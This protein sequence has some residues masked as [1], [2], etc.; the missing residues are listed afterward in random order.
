MRPCIIMHQ[1]HILADISC[2][3]YQIVC[4]DFSNV[5]MRRGYRL[6]RSRRISPHAF[7][8]G[9]PHR[10]WGGHLPPE[11]RKSLP[12]VDTVDSTVDGQ[13]EVVSKAARTVLEEAKKS[14]NLK[15]TTWAK[16]KAAC[17]EILAAADK[18]ADRGE[19]SE[20]I[21]KMAA[22]N[23]RMREELALLRQ[24]TKALR[25]A[26]SE[27]K[28]PDANPL[29]STANI[30]A[31][32]DRSMRSFGESL[33]RNLFL[34]LGGMVNDRIKELE[35]RAIFAPQEVLRPP[36]AADRRNKEAEK[37]KDAEKAEAVKQP[38]NV[39]A[40]AAPKAATARAPPAPSQDASGAPPQEEPTPSS[41][42]TEVVKKGKNKGK[43]RKSSPPE[44]NRVSARPTAPAPVKR[45]YAL[46]KST[47]VVVTL[48]S[49]ATVDYKEVMGRVTT[50]KLATVGVDHVAVRS[51]ATA[52]RII[53]VPGSDS[54]VVA[55]NLAD[56]I[57]ELVGEVA[58]VTRPHKTAQIKIS[59]FDESVT[60]ETL[61]NE[62][63]QAGKCPP[64]HIKVGQIRMTPD[65]TGAVIVICPVAVANALVADGR[66]LIGWSS[67]KI[68]VLEPLP[69]RCFRCMGL[70]HTRALCPS[71]VDRWELCHRCGKM[72]HLTQQ[73]TEKEPWCAVC[74]HAKLP[75]KHTMG[76]KSCNPPRTRGQLEPT[77]LNRVGNTMEH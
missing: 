22:D 41:S 6:P 9:L 47:A 14:G 32:V 27:R 37:A 3:R 19:V 68:T 70:G 10:I 7:G 66:I 59:G 51:T 44:V 20:V 43:G 33:T 74:H 17:A 13:L 65:F 53:E 69:M 61:R 25:T 5:P 45:Q 30:M 26:F 29:A 40:V 34:S 58:E 67:A 39:G 11:R 15:G 49:G 55:D 4:E 35:K 77:G 50:I 36:L 71:P 12:T 60:P 57:R 18:I 48:K 63:S 64:E 21:R 2:V 54:G 56:K 46:P 72:G 8:R 76:G 24:E 31:Q 73:C 62:V 16:M 28:A 75:A 52:A 38:G 42:W 1:L 23:K